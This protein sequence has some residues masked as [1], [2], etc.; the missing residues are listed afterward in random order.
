[1]YIKWHVKQKA[2]QIASDSVYPL[3]NGFIKLPS[4]RRYRAAAATKNIYKKSFIPNIISCQRII[5]TFVDNKDS[6]QY[7]FYYNNAV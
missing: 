6:V 1:M 2:A 7:L 5:S 3:F 4:G